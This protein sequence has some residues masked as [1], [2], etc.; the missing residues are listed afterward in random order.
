MMRRTAH[1][2]VFMLLAGVLSCGKNTPAPAAAGPQSSRTPDMPHGGYLDL[3]A[4]QAAQAELKKMEAAMQEQSTFFTYWGWAHTHRVFLRY[5]EAL[6]MHPYMEA[7]LQAMERHARS[8]RD[9][10]GYAQLTTIRQSLLDEARTFRISAFHVS[11]A[12]VAARDGKHAVEKHEDAVCQ[13][14]YSAGCA[15]MRKRYTVWQE[16]LT[17]GGRAQS[18]QL[19]G[20]QTHDAETV[21]KFRTL[22]HKVGASYRT[23]VAASQ[24]ALAI[25]EQRGDHAG[26]IRVLDDLYTAIQKLIMEAAWLTTGDLKSLWDAKDVV[27]TMLSSRMGIAMQHKAWLQARK[28]GDAAA[29]RRAQVVLEI[30]KKTTLEAEQ[31][32]RNLKL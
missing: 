24:S 13:R 30:T 6:A 29:L 22:L 32:F 4:W 15:L 10:A 14:W 12:V 19:T 7:K 9:V 25:A 20:T 17:R 26:M 27:M 21:P 11:N 18:Q 3:P 1:V 2:I 5:R 28:A 23:T 16:T 8:M 31:A